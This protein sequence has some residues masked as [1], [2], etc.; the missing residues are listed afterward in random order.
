MPGEA[1]DRP[2]GGPVTWLQQCQG[3]VS[4]LN[5]QAQVRFR[6]IRAGKVQDI[7]LDPK[8]PRNILI[9]IVKKWMYC[10]R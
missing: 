6:G 4:G 9:T 8:D 2:M 1:Q 10:F 7:E 5:T 3:S